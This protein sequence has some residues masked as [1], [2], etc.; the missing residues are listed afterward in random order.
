MLRSS[1]EKFSHQK[2]ESGNSLSSGDDSLKFHKSHDKHDRSNRHPKSSRSMRKHHI[3]LTGSKEDESTKH[4]SSKKKKNFER[5]GGDSDKQ[6]NSDSGKKGGHKKKHKEDSSRSSE[7]KKKPK[8]GKKNSLHNSSMKQSKVRFSDSNV[9]NGEKRS[10]DI[11]EVSHKKSRKDSTDEELTSSGKRRKK[12]KEKTRKK[13][14]EGSNDRVK[15]IT[16]KGRRKNRAKKLEVS[17]EEGKFVI[18]NSSESDK[19]SQKKKYHSDSIRKRARTHRSPSQ[20]K[21]RSEDLD[22]KTRSPSSKRRKDNSSPKKHKNAKI[23]SGS[24]QS[25]SSSSKEPKKTK[26]KKI[27]VE[28][29]LIQK[30]TKK[31]LHRSNT[32]V[33]TSKEG[34]IRNSRKKM[35]T[36]RRDRKSKHINKEDVA[37]DVSSQNST[38][39]EENQ[40]VKSGRRNPK[41]S[42][43][44]RKDRSSKQINKDAGT[45]FFNSVDIS[46]PPQVSDDNR[47]DK[48]SD[49]FKLSSEDVDEEKKSGRTKKSRGKLKK[50]KPKKH[51]SE[52]SKEL[53][54]RDDILDKDSLVDKP[55]TQAIYHKKKKEENIDLQISVD[56]AE[57]LDIWTLT[58]IGT[59]ISNLDSQETFNLGESSAFVTPYSIQQIDERKGENRKLRRYN[60][61]MSFGQTDEEDDRTLRR[62]FSG[63]DFSPGLKKILLQIEKEQEEKR[64]V[65]FGLSKPPIRPPPPPPPPVPPPSPAFLLKKEDSDLISFLESPETHVVTNKTYLLEEEGIYYDVVEKFGEIQEKTIS[66]GTTQGIF[67]ELV[68]MQQMHVKNI[69]FVHDIL[70]TY[71]YFCTSQELLDG[72][73]D[74]FEHQPPEGSDDE[75]EKL[76]RRWR[77][78]VRKT[79]KLVVEMWLEDHFQ[80]FSENPELLSNISKVINEKF[81]PVR[82]TWLV[83]LTEILERKI[84]TH[85]VSKY[86]ILPLLH[87]KMDPKEVVEMTDWTSKTEKKKK[88]PILGFSPQHFIKQL[89]IIEHSLFDAIPPSEFIKAKWK[90]PNK[91]ELAPNIC[92]CITWFNTLTVWI[93][94]QIVSVPEV[95]YRAQMVS[96]FIKIAHLSLVE[97]NFNALFAVVSALDQTPVQR[98]ALTMGLLTNKEKSMYETCKETISDANNF[99]LYRQLTNEILQEHEENDD[100]S[101][102][103]LMIP[104]LGIV[105]QDLLL[106]DELPTRIDGLVNLKK[107]KRIS[108]TIRNFR[109][110]ISGTY[111][112]PIDSHFLDWFLYSRHMSASVDLFELSYICEPRAKK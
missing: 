6:E 8:E 23:S 54:P 49:K 72:I 27:S 67:T 101:H 94:Y 32:S 46:V 39:N 79:A 80:D 98:L 58:Q 88:Y 103:P 45:T 95:K 90:K 85:S 110:A 73:M 17:I 83:E 43:S 24:E 105:C 11:V 15:V 76:Y 111:Q 106:V 4:K 21:R 52:V 29:R 22:I 1:S 36:A 57:S 18:S 47:S 48:N 7:E 93:Q 84:S 14:L 31:M 26:K 68:G 96:Y 28:E 30:E 53:S 41:R 82:P 34:K 12:E 78:T 74:R 107:L 59:P 40:S 51:S 2:K 63:I 102:D 92:N 56:R 3:E 66:R 37:G 97:K 86:D 61:A 42:K 75:V 13:N 71:P 109:K 64:S 33:P 19:E 99:M 25:Q 100:D 69:D 50:D 38:D 9:N 112:E 44:G 5:S 77:F 35:K 62:T 89:S 65:L 10:S 104:Y 60:S 81:E 70:Y 16:S 108:T 91:T 55:E 20:V 87:M